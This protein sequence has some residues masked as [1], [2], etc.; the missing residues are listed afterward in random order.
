[1]LEFL[2]AS[3]FTILP[4]S[5]ERVSDLSNYLFDEVRIYKSKDIYLDKI[6]SFDLE[7]YFIH[8][9]G[10]SVSHI[11]QTLLITVSTC[12]STF[13]MAKEFAF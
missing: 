5:R 8:E 6:A 12:K 4:E 10:P 1:M 7:R 13:D 11:K 3:V 9:K 2:L